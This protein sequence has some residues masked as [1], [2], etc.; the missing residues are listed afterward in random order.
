MIR[1]GVECELFGYG[2]L[3]DPAADKLLAESYEGCKVSFG[4]FDA[5]DLKEVTISQQTVL[6]RSAQVKAQFPPITPEEAAM[7]FLG[8]RQTVEAVFWAARRSLTVQGMV[9]EGAFFQAICNAVKQGLF[10]YG[11]SS[12]ATVLLGSEADISQSDIHFSGW[13][14]GEDV[15]LPVTTD[16]IASL[17]PVEGRVSVQT[18]YQQ[19]VEKYGK[20]RVT[21]QALANALQRG[22]K[23]NR[24]GYASNDTA[25][26]A[27]NLN[28]FTLAGF[29]GLPEALPADT[30]VL[31]FHGAVTPIE[32]ANA[33]QAA[34]ALSKLGDSTLQLDLKL[35]LR[36]EVNEHSVTMALN[37][38]KQ[39][40]AGLKVEDSKG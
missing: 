40:V 34:T 13:L 37:Q 35:E 29:L 38:L 25:T 23:D 8:P 11:A 14:I 7:V 20:E 12:S 19:A 28:E 39:R 3:R 1:Q 16:E 2:I 17:V 26:I 21:E 15:P 33:L 4:R 30:R 36:G 18:I 32:L 22:I 24:F 6:L 10:G 5:L 9:Y 27:F 31:R